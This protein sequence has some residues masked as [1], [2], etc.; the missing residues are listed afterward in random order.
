[1]HL[2]HL[3]S[4]SLICLLAYFDTTAQCVTILNLPDTI[5]ACHNTQVQL[6][7]T[8]NLANVDRTTDTTWTPST[9]LSNPNIL[10]PVATVGNNSI[11][12]TLTIDAVETANSVLNGDFEQGNVDFSSA[13]TY[14]APVPNA[15]YPE[16]LYTVT[17]NPHNVHD[18]FASYGD[19]TTGTGNMMVINGASTSI[20]VWCQTFAVQ[21]NTDYDLSAWGAN[22]SGAGNP[23]QLQFEINNVLFGSPLQLPLA[24]GQ[25]VEFFATWNSGPNTSVTI[26]IYDAQTALGGNDF[27]IDD[28]KFQQHCKSTDSVYI[29]VTSM[30][31][32]ITNTITTSCGSATAHFTSSV[33]GDTPDQYAWDFG[34]NGTSTQQ[35]PQHVYTSQ[36]TYTVRLI[37]TKN[38]CHDTTTTTVN[39]AFPPGMNYTISD[40]P[41][42]CLSTTLTATYVS[43]DN[44]AQYLWLFDDNTNANTNPATHV[45]PQ[46]GSHNVT[47]VLTSPQGCKDTFT[48][49]VNLSV[50]IN[51]T[52]SD[53]EVNCVTS[54][55]SANFASG[56]A[57]NTFTWLFD[58][59]ST[60]TGNP[61]NHRFP[62][63]GQHSITL[64][65][66]T[67]PGCSDTFTHVAPLSLNMHYDVSD[68]VLDCK[69]AWFNAIYLS[70]D[71]AAKYLWYFDNNTTDSVA[72]VIHKFELS[73]QNTAT[74]IVTNAQGCR[75]TVVHPFTIVY[76]LTPDFT[77]NPLIPELDMP[78]TFINLSPANAVN[79]TWDFGD[80]TTSTL[81]NPKK[82]YDASGHYKV[83]LT[84]SDTNDC[85]GIVCKYVDA[86]RT[87]LVD[88]PKAFSP[89]GD[90]SN[91]ILYVR[92]VGISKVKFRVYNRWGQVIF[93]GN[94]LEDGWDGTY[95]KQPQPS[96]AYAYTVDVIYK[97]NTT[98][99]KQGNVML[100]R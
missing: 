57:A 84:A 82:L 6:N 7:P 60:G 48:Y 20:N 68:S 94:N 17:T 44:A 16:G 29:K 92:G 87:K 53:S 10:N 74:L 41:I 91:D 40:A 47:L 61:I 12:Y 46:S 69:S 96:D 56:D 33:A 55:L 67:V 28:I 34:D 59:D 2:K 93:E 15:L 26:C 72:P 45:F 54:K 66:T 76:T 19:H 11:M 83:C 70:G 50:N 18:G 51:Y 80:G 85:P 81:R 98:E 36:G 79:F 23:A 31:P 97:D 35:N 52:I 32:S 24:T 3:L 88:V 77:Y 78:I 1:M 5:Q 65:A 37:T 8:L 90:G 95:N 73:G 100:L 27:T 42:S 21:P 22:C 43:G 25:W 14:A 86:I 9:G 62:Q 64:I 58:D 13:Y 89:N 30:Q 49:T 99:E 63:T 4:A 71:T 38:G 39:I 75:D